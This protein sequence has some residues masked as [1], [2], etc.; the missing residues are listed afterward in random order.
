MLLSFDNGHAPTQAHTTWTRV[1][2][3]FISLIQLLYYTTF[4]LLVVHLELEMQTI[5][6]LECQSYIQYTIVLAVISKV[7][8]RLRRPLVLN[9]ID[10]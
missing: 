9:K 6:W 4:T 8:G 3:L 2:M 7:F 5:R 1:Y 10:K